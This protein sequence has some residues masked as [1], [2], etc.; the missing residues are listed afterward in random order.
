MKIT[1]RTGRGRAGVSQ[2]SSSLNANLSL[3]LF[4]LLKGYSMQKTLHY[5]VNEGVDHTLTFNYIVLT[6]SLW[7][8]TVLSIDPLYSHNLCTVL[9]TVTWPEWVLLYI[10]YIATPWAST[11]L[12]LS[13]DFVFQKYVRTKKHE[14]KLG[15]GGGGEWRHLTTSS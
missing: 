4:T 6:Q 12:V 5:I 8:H 9:Q 14:T 15:E 3:S 11:L 7:E 1:N 2:P 10:L 13:L